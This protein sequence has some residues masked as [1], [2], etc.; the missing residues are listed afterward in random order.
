M[1]KKKTPSVEPIQSRAWTVA[2]LATLR[3]SFAT[4]STKD[5]AAKLG[6]TARSV[7]GQAAKLGL[8]K[9]PAHRS[10]QSRRT[11]LAAGRTSEQMAALGSAGG[12]IGGKARAEALT[13]AARKRIAKA[14]IKA[15]WDAARDSSGKLT[16]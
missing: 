16:N 15:R 2:E 8:A 1:A 12:M 13:P 11:A 3:R 7:S 4:T 10:A 5:L 9:V 14:A 6:R